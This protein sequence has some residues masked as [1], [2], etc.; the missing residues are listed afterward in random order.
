MADAI[1]APWILDYLMDIAETYGGDLAS[2]PK[3]EKPYRAQI[4]KVRVKP[5]LVFVHSKKWI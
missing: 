3:S 1:R 4:I 2:V 5:F